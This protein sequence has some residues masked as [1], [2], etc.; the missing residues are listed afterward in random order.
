MF[1]QVICTLE[2]QHEKR[3]YKY[4]SYNHTKIKACCKNISCTF[5]CSFIFVSFSPQV[6]KFKILITCFSSN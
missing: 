6:L 3:N 2:G 1:R 5:I 4:I